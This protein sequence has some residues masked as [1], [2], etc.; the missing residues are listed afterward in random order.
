M[1][2]RCL[3]LLLSCILLP[4]RGEDTQPGSEALAGALRT[5]G[6]PAGAESVTVPLESTF[7]GFIV[8]AQINGK[9]VRLALDTG[10]AITTLS[11]EVARNLGLQANGGSKTL[12]SVTGEKVDCR[13]ALTQR[14]S[15]G[16]AWTKNEPV[17]V[18]EKV[19]IVNGVLGMATLA[20][21]D[22]RID[23][24]A[25][26]L[27]LFP[28][29]KAPPLE[30]ET[31][32]PLTRKLFNADVGPTNPQA[33]HPMNL[34]VPVRIGSHELPANPDTGNGGT[35]QLSSVVMK[36]IAPDA[37]ESARPA[38]VTGLSL[39]GNVVSREASLPEVTFGPDTLRGLP[40]DIIDATPGSIAEREANIG[41]NLL[42]HYVMTFRFKAGELRLK[43]LGTVQD[44]TRTS[45][46]GLQFDFDYK[47]SHLDPGGPA[48]KAGLRAGDEMLEIEGHPLR[49][50]TPEDFAAIKRLPPG[51]AVKVR[52]RRGDLSPVE[53]HIVV[54]KK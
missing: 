15:L 36:K 39:S 46:A 34:R 28:A 44:L 51:T 45:T 38:L 13:S 14:I 3:A 54:V 48:D 24:T 52:Y 9:P 37:L 5:S 17:L 11:S 35:F 49:T 43:P 12:M 41:L 22:V 50:M 33:F 30:G 42:R 1:H 20:D 19:P 29:G 2:L 21:W 47:I 4:L 26:K 18:S 10:A 40:T 23:P 6:L 31:V 16:G 27:T 32:L 7:L 8:E 53:T 25:R